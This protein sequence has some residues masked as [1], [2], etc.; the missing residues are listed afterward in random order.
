MMPSAHATPSPR[1]LFLL[2]CLILLLLV[3]PAFRVIAQSETSLSNLPASELDRVYQSYHLRNLTQVEMAVPLAGLVATVYC[4][5][6]HEARLL[7][8]NVLSPDRPIRHP[9]NCHL[10]AGP[11]ERINLP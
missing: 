4:L 2:H 9:D 11:A 6:R 1:L 3:L 8:P 7:F 10:F 5:E